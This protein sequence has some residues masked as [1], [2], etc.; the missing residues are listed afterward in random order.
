MAQTPATDSKSVDCDGSVTITAS[1]AEGY[2]F[3]R[4]EDGNTD[5]PRTITHIRADQTYKAIFKAMTYTFNPATD[6]AE[7]VTIVEGMTVTYG[8]TI[9]V[10][11]PDI[12]PSDNCEQFAKWSDD[13]TDKSRTFVVS[14]ATI[15][16][17]KA[18]T[19]IYQ[20]IVYSVTV[21]ADDASQGSV[22]VNVLP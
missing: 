6:L 14:S 12:N 13:V 9:T 5:N 18:L 15:A 17:I 3:V 16:Q 10:V 20:P 2:E 4:W 22:S 19:V 11:A 21:N 1:P 7:G 8:Q